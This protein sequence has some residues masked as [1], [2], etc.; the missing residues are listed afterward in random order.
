MLKGRDTRLLRYNYYISLL[1]TSARIVCFS[2]PEESLEDMSFHL[3]TRQYEKVK[4]RGTERRHITLVFAL[5]E[6]STL[7]S[8]Y[9]IFPTSLL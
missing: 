6:S 8:C 4:V 2:L 3:K 1:F 5:E 9:G 7:N